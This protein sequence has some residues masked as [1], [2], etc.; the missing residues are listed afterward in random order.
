MQDTQNSLQM[1]KIV[2][3]WT[4][5]EGQMIARVCIESGKNGQRE[6][7]PG[8]GHMTAHDEDA[9]EGRQQIA[10]DMFNGM[11]V[12]GRNGNGSRPLVVLLVDVLVDAFI[13]QQPM[14]IVEAELFHQ[15]A[16]GQLHAHPMEGGQLP[17]RRNAT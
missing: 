1:M 11:T 13:V 9:Q 16:D 6:P 3:L 2:S 12:D 10:E 7:H 5:K 8:G 17:D 15:Y 4:G 14:W